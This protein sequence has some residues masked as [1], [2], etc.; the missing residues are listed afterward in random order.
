ME[1]AWIGAMQLQC[2]LSQAKSAQSLFIGQLR[3]RRISLESSEE[4]LKPT[5]YGY[6]IST[7][8]HDSTLKQFQMNFYSRFCPMTRLRP[9]LKK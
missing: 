3:I 7:K 5:I 8:L 1:I 4:H 2:S 6:Q 9:R